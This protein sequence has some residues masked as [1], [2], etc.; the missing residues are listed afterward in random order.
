MEGIEKVRLSYCTLFDKICLN[1]VYF[2][3]YGCQMNVNDTE[4][5]W[6]ILKNV[7]YTKTSDPNSVSNRSLSLR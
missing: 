6:S 3:T 1:T 7:G 4:V 2:E 5:A